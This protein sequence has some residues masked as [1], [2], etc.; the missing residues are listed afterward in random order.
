MGKILSPTEI[1]TL[2]Q[3]IL[4]AHNL[5]TISTSDKIAVENSLMQFTDRWQKIYQRFGENL[6]GEL[7]YRDAILFFS[8]EI[9]PKIRKHLS[10]DGLDKQ[11]VAV[12]EFMLLPQSSEQPRQKR[13]PQNWRQ[14]IKRQNLSESF[15]CPEFD[16]P[17]FI[18]SAPR[19]G[20]TLLFE[21]LSGFNELW[22][23]GQ[24]S[25]DIETDIPYLHPASHAYHSNR[26]TT[27]P[28]E[29]IGEV[30]QWF[31]QQLQ[32]HQKQLYLELESRPTSIR[33]LEKTPKNALRIPFL[34]QVFPDARF[35]FLYRNPYENISSL[36]EGWRTNR[37]LAYRDMPRW[38]YKE[39]RFLLPPGWENLASRPLAEI[40]TYQ[41]TAANQAILDDLSGLAPHEWCFVNYANLVKNPANTI[42]KIRIFAE[43]AEEKSLVSETLP[44]SSMVISPPSPDKWRKHEAEII[45]ALPIAEAVI[46]QI[47]LLEQ[48][49]S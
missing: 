2:I 10:A 45:P 12:I 41:W 30:K 42:E 9:V 36:L 3:Q 25:H 31:A 39:W 23:I 20:S 34:K 40:A 16:R 47:R 7:A 37:F 14:S 22:S 33:F 19:S 43:L 8:E 26:L 11:A 32:N 29:I 24:E 21:T 15:E 17:L 35:I 46:E 38:P 27:A 13:L 48:R 6:A 4:S 28:L 18:V 49:L 44:L 5:Q 1:N